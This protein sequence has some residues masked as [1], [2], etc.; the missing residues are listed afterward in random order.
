M[1]PLETYLREL[2]DI[3]S[4]GAGVE[5]ESYYHPL[6][7]LLNEV[8]KKLKPKVKCVL[9]LA[10]RGA[11]KPDGGLFIAEQF[12]HVADAEPLPGQLPAR[13]AI[14]VKPTKDDAWVTAEAKQVTKYWNRYRQVL[15]TNYR[16][17]VLVGQDAE[18]NPA[19]LETYRLADSEKAFWQAAATPR[20]AAEKQN[21]RFV[22]YL[23]RVMR[24]GAPIATPEDVAWF[25]ASYARDALAAIHDVELSALAAVRAALEEA[26]GLKFEGDKGEHFF[27][28]SLVQ[29]LF[30]GI[31]S[32]WVLWSRHNPPASRN[33]FD[34]RLTAWSLRVPMISRLF[35]LVA[36]PQQLDA[37]KLS[38]VLDWTGGVLNRVDRASFFSKFEEGHA[39]QYFYE[40]FLEAFD[41]ELR[42]QLGVWYTPPEIVK[43]MVE[44][45]DTVLRQELGLPLGLADKNVYVL[46]PC[47]GTGSYLVEVLDRIHRTLKERSEDG[48]TASDLKEAAQKRV[49]GFEILPAPFV[50]SHLQLGLLLQKLGVPLSERS[51][52]RVGVYLTN[53]LTGWEPPKGPKQHLI[54]K[55]MEEERDAADH[56]K[57]EVPILVVLGNPPYNAF[58]GVSPEEEQG[59]VEPYKEGLVSEWGIRKFNLD[60]L[61]VRFFRLAE[62]R[63]AE[64]TGSGIICYISNFSYLSDPSFVVMRRRFLR[65]FDRF[66]IDCMNGDSRETGKL[67]PEGKPDPSVFSTEHNREGIRLGTAIA[68]MV[69]RSHRT[70]GRQVH[71]RDFWGVGK[72]AD[73]LATLRGDHL[74]VDY[75]QAEPGSWNRYSLRPTPLGLQYGKWPKPVE[76]CA[77]LPISGLQ[78]M[79]GGALMDAVRGVLSGRMVLYYDRRADWTTVANLGTGLTIDAGR[80]IAAEAR[81]KVIAA[82]T[83]DENHL[84]RYALHPFDTRWCYY[85]SVRPLWNEPRPTLAAQV[86]E[87][88][89]LFVTRMIAERPHEHAPMTVTAVL[90]DYHLLRPNAVAIPMRLLLR[91]SRAETAHGQDQQGAFGSAGASRQG[92]LANLSGRARLFLRQIGI[93]NPDED[94]ETAESIWMHCLAIGYSPAYLTENT[95]GIRQDWPRIPLPDSKEL[96]LGSAA[97]GRKIA[98]L[99]DTETPFDVAAPFGVPWVGQAPPLQ[100]I[101][102]PTRVDGRPLDET[103]DLAVT[104]GWGHAGKGGVTMPGKG[105]LIERDYTPEERDM[106]LGDHTCDVYLN[107]VAY[108]K[109]IPLRVWEYTIGGYQAIK[110]WLSYR[111]E[112][113]LGRPMTK[114]EVRWVQE[115]SRR[116][117]AILL[118]EPA[119][120]ENYRAVKAHTYA[121]PRSS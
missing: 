110:K 70:G 28:S 106:M 91:L 7:A 12:E 41:P 54:F 62:R 112:K 94:A 45:V 52:D 29:T 78:E 44:R 111:E 31:F 93:E 9:Q 35:E 118:F 114:D 33:P 119:L 20:S 16:D 71:Y 2:R 84:R 95:C 89:R 86:W 56:V 6:A 53:S 96:L 23:E 17:F 42:K 104:A 97:L 11:G 121:W 50:V 5:E 47:C 99:L 115:M 57:R 90:P 48:L 76:L 72:R 102:V 68:L 69:R 25:L 59:L 87:G 39:V 22:E 63:I 4:T 61:Y 81:R 43:Y 37:L 18:S 83:Y 14:E 116:I 36:S 8:G 105:R 92:P 38:E 19:I 100:R 60:D 74:D 80:F 77:E 3:R 15:V 79:R 117:A 21:D 46:D 98:A 73:L 40:P 120:D 75:R 113:L 27:R 13:G 51:Q 30:Y 49:F 64:K 82:E 107:D 65:E 55:E 67:T 85:S 26:L 109:D 108:W 58:A 66:W 24:H 10:N 88:N 32:A 101:A 1:T 103:K 34:W